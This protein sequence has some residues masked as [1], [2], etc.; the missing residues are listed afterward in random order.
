MTLSDTPSVSFSD[1]VSTVAS[2]FSLNTGSTEREVETASIN[3][4]NAFFLVSNLQGVGFSDV[5]C[6]PLTIQD[7]DRYPANLTLLYF[8]FYH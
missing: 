7:P 1:L 8:S 5:S 6:K 2:Y 3:I 4:R